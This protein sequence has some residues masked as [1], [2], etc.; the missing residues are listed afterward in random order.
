MDKALERKIKAK[1]KGNPKVLRVMNAR[2]AAETAFY[3]RERRDFADH[4]NQKIKKEEAK[5]AVK[6]AEAKLK[7]IKRK[8][9]EHEKILAVCTQA[10]AYTAVSLGDG[11]PSGGTRQHQ[12]HRFAVLDLIRS[13]S[14]LTP[15]QNSTWVAF[16]VLW[17]TKRRQA[18]D[19]EWGRVFAEETHQILVELLNGSM[20]ALSKWMENERQRVL[21][22]EGILLL[23]HIEFV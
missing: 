5:Q 7:E 23:P 15:P 20:D 3:N 8:Q 1:M 2:L 9:R 10:R 16:T 12:K 4:M 6:A 11:K 18:V 14:D 22:N 21:P 13:V 19:T 17:D